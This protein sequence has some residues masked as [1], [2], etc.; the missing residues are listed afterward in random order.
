MKIADLHPEFIRVTETGF[1]RVPT[2]GEAQGI[3]FSCPKCWAA[4]G[5]PVGTHM[6]ICWSRGVPDDVRP[7]PGRWKIEGTG[8]HDV[9]LNADPPG[10]A[11]SVALE[12]GC[13]W[14]GFVTNGEARPDG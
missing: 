9:T 13:A 5:G 3:M 1:R 11:R 2:L 7:S 12:G 4:N 8:W 14:H 6:V 10:S